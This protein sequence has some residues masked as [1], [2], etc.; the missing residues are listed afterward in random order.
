M[1][2]PKTT[3]SIKKW[4]EE[5]RPREKLIL[6]GRAALTDAELMAILIGSG[7]RTMSAVELCKQLL[8]DV[9]YDLNQLAKL[10]MVDLKKYKGM[11]EAKALAIIS[12]LELGRRRNDSGVTKKIK[13]QSSND[14][15]AIMK[16]ALLDL[17]HEEF[18]IIMLNRANE[19]IKKLPLSVGGI[20]G[21]VVDVRLI[22]KTAL[23]NLATA[24]IL[25][26]NH[27]S[28]NTNP[29]EADIL[30]TTKLK[31]AGQ[32]MEITVL[33]HVIFADSGYYSFADEGRIV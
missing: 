33:D 17:P 12:A 20:V 3:L 18:W 32:L 16:S 22:F 1:E 10:S 26:H 30:L 8:S 13:I 29:S 23:D 11:G 27:P 31:E 6:K 4:A 24:I 25:V 19:V 14:I 21:T 9:D 5:D 28:G 7:N 2:Y 15:Y